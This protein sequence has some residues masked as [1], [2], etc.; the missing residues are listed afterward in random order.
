MQA[1]FKLELLALLA[2]A[3]GCAFPYRDDWEKALRAR[4][5]FEMNCPKDQL[6]IAPLTEQTYGNTDAPLYQGALGCGRR[7]V[8]VATDSGY[9][10]NSGGSGG[11]IPSHPPPAPPPVAPPAH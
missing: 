10:L 5:P 9:V 8:Y 7:A 3:T 2:V 4:A 1:N 11:D 6:R